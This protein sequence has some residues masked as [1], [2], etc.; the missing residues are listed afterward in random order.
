MKWIILIISLSTITNLMS[1][2]TCIGMPKKGSRPYFER[3]GIR[4]TQ[5]QLVQKSAQS[6]KVKFSPKPQFENSTFNQQ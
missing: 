3:N 6:T 4:Y 2:P 5:P 1:C